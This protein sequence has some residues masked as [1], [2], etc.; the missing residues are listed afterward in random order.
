MIPPE[1]EL[2]KEQ[3]KQKK[4]KKSKKKKTQITYEEYESISNAISTFLRSKEGEHE[5]ADDTEEQASLNQYLTWG[6]TVE[7][8]LEQCEEQIGSSEE[9]LDRLKK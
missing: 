4:K 2:E 9:E 8:Y 3:I 6:E 1:S 5:I 7:W